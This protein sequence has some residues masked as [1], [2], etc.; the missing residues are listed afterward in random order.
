MINDDIYVAKDKDESTED[1]IVRK[2]SDAG[3]RLSGA[4]NSS[5]R[6]NSGKDSLLDE[7]YGNTESDSPVCTG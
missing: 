7:G 1:K 6:R 2:F 3:R 5:Q 4:G